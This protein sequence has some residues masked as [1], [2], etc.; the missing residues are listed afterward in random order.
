[1]EL[2][3][4]PLKDRIIKEVQPPPH[5]PLTKDL[6]WDKDGVPKYKVIKDHLLKEGKFK[7]EDLLKLVNQ[8][9]T[10]LSKEG[11]IIK[12]KD[13]VTIVGDIHGQFYDLLALLDLGGDPSTNQYLFMGDYVDRG[14]FSIECVLLLYAAKL[15]YPN[16]VHLLRGNHECRQLTT[17][18]NFKQECDIKFDI[19]VYN[20]IMASFDA[21]PL[22]CI[23]NNKF[24][25]VHGGLSPNLETVRRFVFFSFL[26]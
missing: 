16:Q 25:S 5:L 8:A 22:G 12:I 26:L 13:P 19:E 7:K 9:T 1:M 18:F 11:N 6:I 23:I 20:A 14:A 4:D 21:L 3:P 10:L 2:L 17:Y 15:A 24:V